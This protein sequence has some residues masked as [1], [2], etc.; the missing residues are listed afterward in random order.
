MSSRM[1][2]GGKPVSS[3]R[4]WRSSGA[5]S[6]VLARCCQLNGRGHLYSLEDG[7]QFAERARGV[8]ADEPQAW[9]VCGIAKGRLNRYDAALE[10]FQRYEQ[11]LPGNPNTVFFQGLC[12]EGM[13]KKEPA[14]KAY[15]AYLQQVQEGK[16]AQ[17][18]YQRLKAWGYIK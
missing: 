15:N 3:E 13:D 14:A 17:H 9:H 5:T 10:D 6:L 7:A 16:Q 18:A 12:L 1:A 8:Y 2:E 4:S 11:R